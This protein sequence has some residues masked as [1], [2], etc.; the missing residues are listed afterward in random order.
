MAESYPELQCVDGGISAELREQ[1]RTMVDAK[2]LVDG[3]SRDRAGRRLLGPLYDSSGLRHGA[4]LFRRV[5][6]FAD[7]DHDGAAFSGLV[8]TAQTI[9]AS[10][11]WTTRALSD[12][13][14][15]TSLVFLRARERAS[16]AA[17]N[18]AEYFWIRPLGL[19]LAHEGKNRVGFF[20]DMQV[21]WIPAWVIPCKYI[22]ADRLS[23]YR[24]SKE[25]Q[26]PTYW[27]VLDEE[28]L[29]PLEHPDWA[30][31][32]LK[33]YGVQV[34]RD[35]P[36]EFPSLKLTA[37]ALGDRSCG[38]ISH[39]LP[40]LNLP[41]VREKNEYESEEVTCSLLDIK[42]IK[43]PWRSLLWAGAVSMA[44]II[45]FD[46]LPPAWLKLRIAAAVV[47][48]AG[49]AVMLLPSL[50]ILRLPRRLVD[51]YA[52][53]RKFAGKGLPPSRW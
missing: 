30:L 15:E 20:R 16:P 28:W 37:A 3:L 38:S 50:R 29:E 31:P 26:S 40:A 39:R 4:E 5:F 48:G 45:A 23:I 53:Q 41:L 9:G 19:F 8:P 18:H 49:C 7:I 47:A 1:I 14:R 2:Y 51:P 46:A 35:W 34:R 42:G 17:E 25:R 12:Q 21:D 44:A 43:V 13:E 32:V 22:A 24:I 33:A 36:A 6:P 10:E 11:R 52:A 27:A